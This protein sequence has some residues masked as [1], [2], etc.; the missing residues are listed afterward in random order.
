MSSAVVYQVIE[1][2]EHLTLTASIEIRNGLQYS[3]MV[4]MDGCVS[5]FKIDFG[6]NV[7]FM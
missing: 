5:Y 4:W 1:G 3:M 2:K 7:V 6:H